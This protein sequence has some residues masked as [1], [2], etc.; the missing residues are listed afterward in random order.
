MCKKKY[1][2]LINFGTVKAL[3]IN[4]ISSTIIKKIFLCVSENGLK[5]QRV[6]R[7]VRV[8]K[9]IVSAFSYSW[10]KKEGI[11]EG[12]TRTKPAT[13]QAKNSMCYQ[14]GIDANDDCKSPRTKE[15]YYTGPF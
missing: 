15:S 3:G 5:D 4:K 2:R 6:T 9:N 12:A 7:A 10:E 13:T 14:M 1:K 8:C 11:N